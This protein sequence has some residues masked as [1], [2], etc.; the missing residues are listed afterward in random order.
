GL[1]QEQEI[2]VHILN[3]HGVILKSESIVGNS[4]T[5]WIDVSGLP[6]GIYFLNFVSINEQVSKTIIKI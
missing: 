6:S 1:T 5:S 4:G 2:R 3:S